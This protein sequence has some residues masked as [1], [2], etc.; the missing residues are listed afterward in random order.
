MQ[1]VNSLQ[2]IHLQTKLRTCTALSAGLF[3]EPL[4]DELEQGEDEAQRRQPC[5]VARGITRR[6]LQ[7]HHKHDHCRHDLQ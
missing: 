2:G 7:G 4:L 1:K 5:L 6:P 3:A